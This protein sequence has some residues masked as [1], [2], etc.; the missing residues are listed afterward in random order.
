MSVP[1]IGDPYSWV[2]EVFSEHVH[3]SSIKLGAVA[4]L[5]GRVVLVNEAHRFF[6]VEAAFPGGTLREC[7]KF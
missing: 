5:N 3:L 4:R 2:P 7:F 6:R 1:E